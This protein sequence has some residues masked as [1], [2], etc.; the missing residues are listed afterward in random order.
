MWRQGGANTVEYTRYERP[1]WWEARSDSKAFGIV[2]TARVEPAG[3]GSRLVVRMDLRPHGVTRLISP[4]LLRV[5]QRQ[6]V[7][8]LAAVKRWMESSGV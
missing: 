2:F 6:E 1:T 4:I 8:N 5:M 7:L 3:A